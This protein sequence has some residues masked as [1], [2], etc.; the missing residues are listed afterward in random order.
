MINYESELMHHGVKGMKWGV[1]KYYNKDGSLKPKGQKAINS[2]K[3]YNSLR[4]KYR[5]L[6]RKSFDNPN[7]NS[8]YLKADKAARKEDDYKRKNKKSI[9]IGRK[10]AVNQGYAPA[11]R[12]HHESK[13]NK[14]KAAAI[15]AGVAG[16]LLLRKAIKDNGLKT[17]YDFSGDTTIST[18]Y[19]NK[20]NRK[21]A[22]SIIAASSAITL[23]ALSKRNK[24]KADNSR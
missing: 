8:A 11:V 19:R 9:K 4:G 3:T 12:E 7:S 20:R 14:Q 22:A 16:G 18:L 1:L 10:I 23:A 2:Y 5:T 17:L 21:I 24:K 15:G 6:K 13:S